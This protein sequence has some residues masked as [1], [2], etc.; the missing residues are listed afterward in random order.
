[1]H[2]LVA[3]A[4]DLDQ[5]SAVAGV[6]LVSG[7]DAQV[8]L[9]RGILPSL[10]SKHYIN[11]KERTYLVKLPKHIISQQ[12]TGHAFVNHRCSRLR[13]IALKATNHIKFRYIKSSRIFSI[14]NEHDICGGIDGCE[15]V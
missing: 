11:I 15:I 13:V 5:R 6:D 4:V 1:M 10:Q 12:P 2:S 8:N 7:V 3:L 9:H 14:T